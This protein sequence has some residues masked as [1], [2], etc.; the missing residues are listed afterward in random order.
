MNGCRNCG[1]AVRRLHLEV[2]LTEFV[3]KHAWH[4]LGVLKLV[5]WDSVS[6]NNAY[7]EVGPDQ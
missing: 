4:A 6:I 2:D 5:C 3:V 1:F 7:F